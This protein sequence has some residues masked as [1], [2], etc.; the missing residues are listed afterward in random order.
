[1]RALGYP[2][3][4]V[5]TSTPTLLTSI[6]TVSPGFIHTGGLRRAPTPP[7]VPV[8]MTSPGS[9]GC[10]GRDVIDEPRD[11]VNHLLGG[12]VLHDLAVEAGLQNQLL[13]V[14]DLAARDHPRAESAGA[15]EVLAC[16][17]LQGVALPI[18]HRAVVV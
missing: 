17:P 2:T 8:T 7:G 11:A 4:I 10:E 13:A 3:L 1:M 16:S 12:G 5:L 15:A 18:A 14:R 6:S 9:K